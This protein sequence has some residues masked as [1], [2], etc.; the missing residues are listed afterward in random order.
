MPI[1]DITQNACC[2]TIELGVS[3]KDI[4]RITLD[5]RNTAYMHV[6]L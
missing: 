5:N 3:A 6:C 1:T 4:T 2:Y